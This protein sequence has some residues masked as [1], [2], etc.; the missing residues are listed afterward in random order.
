[1]EES[2]PADKRPSTGDSGPVKVNVA[3]LAATFR[4]K[5]EIYQFLIYDAKVFLPKIHS[6]N[7]FF[8]KQIL[9]GEKLTIKAEEVK[10]CKVPQIEGL[11]VDDFLKYV[12]LNQRLRVY[13]PDH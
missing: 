2:Y 3:Q 5:K 1:M 9:K 13:L 12:A 11:R 6:T 10:L 4:T 8:Y 7:A